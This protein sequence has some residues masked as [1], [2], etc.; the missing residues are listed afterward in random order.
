MKREKAWV[1]FILCYLSHTSLYIA[2]L[3]LTMAN[4]SFQDAG[5]ADAVQ[6][7]WLAGIF[8]VVYALGRLLAG[9]VSDKRPP[10]QMVVTGLVT[11]GISNIA[12]SFFPPFAA[13]AVLW[14]TGAFGQSMLWG[15]LLR[16]FSAVYDGETAKK[17]A[18]LL[19]SAV[20]A[21]SVIGILINGWLISA[22]GLTYAFIVPG[23]ITF[24]FALLVL[25][26]TRGACPAPKETK[27][28][29]QIRELFRDAQI[30]RVLLPALLHGVMKDNVSFWMAAFVVDRFGLDLRSS[31]Y[32]VLLVPLVGLGGRLVYPLLYKISGY[33]EYVITAAAFGGCALA[34][35]PLV[36]GAGVPIIAVA[37]MSLVYA[38]TSMI[39]ATFLS[40][41]P[42][43]YAATDR[44]ASVSGVMDFVSYMGAGIGS[45]VYGYTVSVAGY[46]PMFLSWA[47]I[48]VISIFPLVPMIKKNLSK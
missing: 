25:W 18:S 39:N 36:F 16:M 24:F 48:S 15:S 8:S 2:R 5:I 17:R 6:L 22:A 44:V 23:C 42:M 10:W 4:K 31:T 21:G 34:C 47:A 29:G 35:L 38:F 14:G 40:I 41:L 26:K 46:T 7:G 11:V 13:M 3:N 28:N 30:R 32:Y 37:C 33:R 12:F 20:A 27:Q 9:P 1:I 43:S 19:S 45:A